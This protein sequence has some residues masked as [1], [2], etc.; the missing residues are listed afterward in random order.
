[1]F[2]AFCATLQLVACMGANCEEPGLPDKPTAHT[3]P[4]THPP[5]HSPHRLQDRWKGALADKAKLD[6]EL[7]VWVGVC[8]GD[9]DRDL[10]AC[11]SLCSL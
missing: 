4:P 2:M 11:F 6:A 5:T 7:Q 9:P 10:G 3:Y 1:M 8:G